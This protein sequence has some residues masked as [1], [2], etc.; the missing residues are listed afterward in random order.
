MKKTVVLG[1]GSGI[2]AYKTLTLIKELRKQDIDV[3]VIMTDK[4]TKM[5]SPDAFEKAS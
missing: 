3:F 1:V 5:I 2:A 4:A